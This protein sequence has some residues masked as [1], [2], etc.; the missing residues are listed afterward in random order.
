M[1]S[2]QNREKGPVDFSAVHV[3]HV[4]DFSKKGEANAE[5]AVSIVSNASVAQ[6]APKPS[7]SKK[8]EYPGRFFDL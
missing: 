4:I 5:K 6:Q 2:V 8:I 7:L 1:V 3:Q